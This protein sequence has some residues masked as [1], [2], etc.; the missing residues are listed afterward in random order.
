MNS[1]QELPQASKATTTLKIGNT[2]RTTKMPEPRDYTSEGQA[3]RV[4][5]AGKVGRIIKISGSHGLCYEVA[6]TPSNTAFFD[7]D[8]ITLTKRQQKQLEP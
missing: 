6:I 2:V 4:I 3:K 5:C 8:E 7:P 1:I